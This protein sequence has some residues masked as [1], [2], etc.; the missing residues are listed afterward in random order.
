MIIHDD[1]ISQLQLCWNNNNND[2]DEVDD[3]DDQKLRK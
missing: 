2:D 3:G 1:F